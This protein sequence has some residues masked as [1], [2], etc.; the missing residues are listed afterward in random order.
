MHPMLSTSD[1]ERAPNNRYSSVK[2][3]YLVDNGRA[4][5]NY[6]VYDAPARVS[7]G[8]RE[9]LGRWC[10]RSACDGNR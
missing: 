1:A 9:P 7:I 3:A 6:A 10:P 2:L 5:S 4:L 8:H